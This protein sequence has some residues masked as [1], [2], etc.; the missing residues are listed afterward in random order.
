M[1]YYSYLNTAV[2]ILDQYK[3]DQPFASFIKN[4]FSQEKKH[5]SRDRKLISHL[6]Y[7]YFRL[8]HA[9]PNTSTEEKILAGLFLC[10][11]EPNEILKQLKA[12]WDLEVSKPFWEKCSILHA[13][14]SILNV[15]PWKDN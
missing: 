11:R 9:F 2:G 15:F 12:A 3:G 6:C 13:E 8:G 14:Q 5:G 10:S 7:C 4:Y 1:R